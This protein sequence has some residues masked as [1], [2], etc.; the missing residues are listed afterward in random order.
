MQ[1]KYEAYESTLNSL[2]SN[3]LLYKAYQSGELSFLDYFA[4]LQFYRKA[5]DEML[6]MQYELHISQTQLLK[7]QL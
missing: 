6:R 5:Y 7:H 3:E 2:N 4:E 1:E